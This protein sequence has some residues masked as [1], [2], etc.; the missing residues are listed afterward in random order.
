MHM[1]GIVNT[2]GTIDSLDRLRGLFSASA[3]EARSAR[4]KG[5]S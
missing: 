4:F 1:V 3:N 5:R 2:Y